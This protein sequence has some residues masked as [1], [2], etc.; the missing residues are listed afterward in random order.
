MFRSPATKPE[1]DHLDEEFEVENGSRN[2]ICSENHNLLNPED[3]D[4]PKFTWQ[5][6]CAVGLI[7]FLILTTI[8]MVLGLG[9]A[10]VNNHRESDAAASSNTT[11]DETVVGDTTDTTTYPPLYNEANNFTQDAWQSVGSIDAFL[12][13]I[14][15]D[16]SGFSVS[17]S[18][19]GTRLAV[20][21]PNANTESGGTK[22]GSVTIVEDDGNGT[23]MEVGTLKGTLPDEQFGVSV[24]LS[25]D[26]SFVSVGSLKSET[27]GGAVRVYR[28][29]RNISARFLLD[30]EN[31]IYSVQGTVVNASEN[32]IATS[33]GIMTFENVSSNSISNT[34]DLLNIAGT[35]QK[36][37]TSLLV[38]VLKNETTG[39]EFVAC[40][41]ASCDLSSNSTFEQV[42][43]TIYHDQSTSGDFFGYSV[44]MS[45]DGQQLAVGV[46][47]LQ[48]NAGGAF[49]YTYDQISNDWKIMKVPSEAKPNDYLGWSVA[50]SGD[51]STLALG[52]PHRTDKLPGYVNLYSLE[53][54][55][56]TKVKT[57]LPKDLRVNNFADV[58]TDDF[59][60]SVSL[61]S[62]GQTLVIGAPNSTIVDVEVKQV[63]RV[64]GKAKAGG[65]YVAV[66][67]KDPALS[68]WTQMGEVLVGEAGE[69]LGY[70]VST[71]L[72][73]SRIV[74]GAP[75]CSGG[76]GSTRVYNFN[77][78][79]RQWAMAPIL[80]GA[81][82]G[83]DMGFSVSISSTGGLISAGSPYVTRCKNAG[84]VCEPGKVQ[85]FQDPAALDAATTL[86]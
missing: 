70:S 29:H 19:L 38:F 5:K 66:F 73:G 36:S 46:P 27:G 54:N 53:S 56:W 32:G 63:G 67:S 37:P 28:I 76:I 17:L 12:P 83:D 1:D 3:R 48:S 49:V 52:A 44:S 18:G 71:S 51:G 13:S 55:S 20:G 57:I 85:V 59:G 31:G 14:P 80:T 43:R 61:D 11:T 84:D 64:R 45:S 22:A 23:W 34:T 41:G 10:V 26:G 8:F 58:E 50:M 25:E 86:L 72:A 81:G 60:F 62:N 21:S 24:A 30:T 65:G 69:Q 77:G 33:S 9:Y 2:N 47:H 7:F 42:G 68:V 78:Q 4:E 39:N 79:N 75:N 82:P 40:K 6:C 15:G 16:S 74:A 35:R